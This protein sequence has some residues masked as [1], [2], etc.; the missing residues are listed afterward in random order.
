MQ[1]P[2]SIELLRSYARHAPDGLPIDQNS[3]NLLKLRLDAATQQKKSRSN[4]S[5]ENVSRLK[6]LIAKIWTSI[7][8]HQRTA[9]E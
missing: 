8:K 3:R 6:L 7:A 4:A 2:L 5:A 1:G 9:F